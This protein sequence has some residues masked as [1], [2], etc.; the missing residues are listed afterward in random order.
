[1]GLRRLT[2]LHLG[3]GELTRIAKDAFKDLVSLEILNLSGN[4]LTTLPPSIFRYNGK[5]TSLK[6]QRN[7]WLC[8]CDLLPLA[9]FLSETS[10]C[11]EG[12]CGTCRHPSAYHGMPISNL[13]RIENPPCA[14]LMIGK[15]PRPSL[16]VSVGDS[17]RI[18]C[19]TLTP[20]YR[21]TTKKIEWKM[22]NGTS[23]EHGKYLVRITILGNG[24]LNFTKV[25]L[26][27]KGYYTCS[28]FQAGNKI[29]T[30]T[31]F[32]NVTS[33]TNLLTSSYFAT[34]TM[35]SKP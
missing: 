34:E 6:L 20:N 21:T 8:N 7:P 28:V 11:T 2:N 4:N 24:S 1:M 5:L 35:V 23:I 18:P 29:D 25:T 32:L 13:T 12:L 14:A 30:S 10:A 31:V 22:P 17:I 9:G 26:K 16:N 15:K 19:P 33:Q 27:D 3:Y